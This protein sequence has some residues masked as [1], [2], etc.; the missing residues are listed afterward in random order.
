MVGYLVLDAL[1]GNTDRH[2]ENWGVLVEQREQDGVPPEFFLRLA[3]TYDHASSLGRELTDETRERYLH[4]GAMERYIWKG[5]GGIFEHGQAERGMS[6][7]A[8]STMLAQRYPEFFQ[9]WRSR[10]EALDE[11]VLCEL[12]ERLPSER[13]TEAGRRFALAFLSR[14]RNLISKTL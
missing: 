7:M 9:P 14:T 10:V 8:L 4:E 12:V 2:H 3:P 11:K 13:V 5:R 6:P 1:V